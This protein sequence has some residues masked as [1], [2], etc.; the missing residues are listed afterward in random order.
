MHG[1]KGKYLQGFG[2][3]RRVKDWLEGMDFGESIIF[4]GI[5]EMWEG[6]SRID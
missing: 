4:D 3:M 2:W 1:G 6:S 5:L